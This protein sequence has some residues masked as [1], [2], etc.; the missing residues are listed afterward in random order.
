[1]PKKLIQAIAITSVLYLIMGMSKASTS[2]TS[3][4]VASDSLPVGAQQLAQRLTGAVDS[5]R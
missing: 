4:V 1:M 5:S 3:P 2:A